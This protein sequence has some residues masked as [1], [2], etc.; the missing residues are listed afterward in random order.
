[1]PQKAVVPVV[2]TAV[3][4]AS[5]LISVTSSRRLAALPSRG[6]Q[7]FSRPSLSTR[8]ARARPDCPPSWRPPAP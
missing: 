1:M 5:A 3:A 2:A 4:F 8:F 6:W 7:L